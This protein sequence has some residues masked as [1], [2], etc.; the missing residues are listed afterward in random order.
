MFPFKRSY[1]DT[2]LSQTSPMAKRQRGGANNPTNPTSNNGYNL[3]TTN[4]QNPGSAE[5]LI[6]RENTT[7]ASSNDVKSSSSSS[8][9]HHNN[10]SSSSSS[11]VS[12]LRSTNSSSTNR[13]NSQDTSYKSDR[14][15]SN[16]KDEMPNQDQRKVSD[17]EAADSDVEEMLNPDSIDIGLQQSWNSNVRPEEEA[18][19]EWITTCPEFILTGTTYL[20][21][22]EKG[23]EICQDKLG[24]HGVHPSKESLL[25]SHS[26]AEEKV[27]CKLVQSSFS[28]L[29]KT[30]A[31]LKNKCKT[32]EK[33]LQKAQQPVV[34]VCKIRNTVL[35][36]KAEADAAKKIQAVFK[37]AELHASKILKE[38]RERQVERCNT[39]LTHCITASLG[40]AYFLTIKQLPTPD[41]SKALRTR[42]SEALFD[43]MN[44]E[45]YTAEATEKE[46]D[47][48]K[49][50][51]RFKKQ[52][53]EV[54]AQAEL[55]KLFKDKDNTVI[56]VVREELGKFRQELQ[57]PHKPVAS[58]QPKGNKNKNK[59]KHKAPK[60]AQ[61]VNPPNHITHPNVKSTHRNGKQ[62]IKKRNSKPNTKTQSTKNKR[63]KK[64]NAVGK[65]SS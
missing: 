48:K 63:K 61:G 49:Q 62:F 16:G 1:S 40:Y 25:M 28:L 37:A 51:Q 56:Q 9:S 30:R 52:Q 42:I 14:G 31:M 55:Q 2:P 7:H 43:L 33:A 35:L 21:A 17:K 5:G 27:A 20:Q 4:K 12:Y 29:A 38:A 39:Q 3:N 22:L 50:V 6:S 64:A 46:Q 10:G 65:K 60:N 15:P 18:I 47:F 54:A 59:K 13:N 32:A 58:K 24:K 36:P 53:E 26:T 45:V 23:K 19:E 11:Q 44:D 34:P 41:V 57:H 8:N